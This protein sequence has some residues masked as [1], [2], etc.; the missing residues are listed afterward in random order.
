M[1]VS[2]DTLEEAKDAS[3]AILTVAVLFGVSVGI[4]LILV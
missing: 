3:I 2:H 4:A 1:N